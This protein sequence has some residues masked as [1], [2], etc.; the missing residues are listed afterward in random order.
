[1]VMTNQDNQFPVG[2]SID[3]LQ[4]P[5]NET[6]L[7]F[8]AVCGEL[9]AISDTL[10]SWR[11]DQ[12]NET[13]GQHVTYALRKSFVNGAAV[14]GH[15]TF[16]D[17]EWLE[18]FSES[19]TIRSIHLQ[20][21]EGIVYD[22]SDKGKGVTSLWVRKPTERVPREEITP[23]IIDIDGDNGLSLHIEGMPDFMNAMELAIAE[24]RE[25]HELGLDKPTDGAMKEFIDAIR[26]ALRSGVSDHGIQS[27]DRPTS[28]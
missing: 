28:S 12:V 25:A 5:Q 20:T 27:G 17:D 13:S 26:A 1:M 15:S 16:G 24:R 18:I 10:G 19:M 4:E 7:A 21:A 14:T 9:D 23:D 6:I 22:Y 8:Q 3:Q 11:D 2:F